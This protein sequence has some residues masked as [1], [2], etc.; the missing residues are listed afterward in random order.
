MIFLLP[1]CGEIKITKGDSDLKKW[2]G[3]QDMRRLDDV[4]GVNAVVI[5]IFTSIMIL[6]VY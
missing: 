1:L 4:G 5:R 6:D 2:N 3:E